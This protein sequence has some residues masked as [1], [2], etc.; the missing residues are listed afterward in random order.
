MNS[1]LMS[2]QVGKGMMIRKE[3]YKSR[4]SFAGVF[5]RT[6]VKRQGALLKT[7]IV[8][9]SAISYPSPLAES[10]SHC[11]SRTRTTFCDIYFSRRQNRAVNSRQLELILDLDIAHHPMSSN[12]AEPYKLTKAGFPSVYLAEDPIRWPITQFHDKVT[13]RLSGLDALLNSAVTSITVYQDTGAR[14]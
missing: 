9:N 5:V 14:L 1:R 4:L 12:K 7:R 8:L 13:S 6:C 3:A 11:R 10:T 2:I